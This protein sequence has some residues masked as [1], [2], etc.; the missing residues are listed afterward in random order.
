MLKQKKTKQDD[1]FLLK[2]SQGADFMFNEINMPPLIS[3]LE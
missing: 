2:S 1:I 3:S